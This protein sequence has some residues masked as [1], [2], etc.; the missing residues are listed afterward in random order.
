MNSFE[1]IPASPK[2]ILNLP[3]DG[4]ESLSLLN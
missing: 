1:M 4:K 3:V 2:Q